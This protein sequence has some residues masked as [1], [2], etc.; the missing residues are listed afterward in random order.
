MEM[1]CKFLNNAVLW[2]M[3]PCDKLLLNFINFLLDK[4]ISLP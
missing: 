3:T 1:Y 4:F 2:N